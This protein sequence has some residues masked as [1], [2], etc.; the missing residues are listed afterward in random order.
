MQKRRER[1]VR[2]RRGWEGCS[3]RLRDARTT[4]HHRRLEEARRCHPRAPAGA[5]I[6]DP[7]SSGYERAHLPFPA[8]GLRCSLGPQDTQTIW[9]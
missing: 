6:P 1:R 4:G 5:G 8:P 9:S 3:R 7:R 2:Q